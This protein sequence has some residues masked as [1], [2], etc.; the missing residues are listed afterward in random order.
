MRDDFPENIK[1]TLAK[2]VAF[3]CSN[4]ACNMSTIGPNS[5]A[6]STTSIGVAAHITAASPG[7]KRYDHSANTE[8]RASIE[9]AIWLCQ[10]C[11]KLIDSDESKYSI[12]L[13]NEWKLRAENKAAERLNKQIGIDHMFAQP[14]DHNNIKEN[15]YYEKEFSGQ[16][17]R[18]FLQGPFLHVEHEPAPGIIAYYV[19]DPN[20]NVVQ[21]K[22]PYDLSEYEYI[23]EPGLIINRTYEI[24][25]NKNSK[26]TIFMKWGKLAIFIRNPDNYIIHFQIEKGCTIDHVLKKIWINSPSFKQQ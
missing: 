17:V 9:N 7:G 13:L 23:I 12:K 4:P 22:F 18:Y 2:R 26:E 16:K 24:L 3:I 14:S 5:N 21:Q 15:G 6:N 25:Q 8:K 1:N 11:S 10:S 20:G 19:M